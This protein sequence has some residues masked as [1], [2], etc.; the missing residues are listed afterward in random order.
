MPHSL[1]DF[2]D[3]HGGPRTR[4]AFDAPRA[5]RVAHRADE[6]GPVLAEVDRHAAA[7]GWAVGYLRYEAA[8][9]FDAAFVT[10]PPDGPLAWFGLH[11]A[12]RAW[13]DES[14]PGEATAV[15]GAGP[16]R[17]DFDHWVARSHAAIARGD[18]Y[19][20]NLT[21]PWSG[22][23]AGAPEALFHAMRRAQPGGYAAWIAHAHEAV[24]SVSPELFF[25]WDGERLLTRPMKGTAPR[26][27]DAE[28]DR[29]LAEGLRSAPKERA[30]NVMIV[31][32]LRND[33]SR[34]A[35]PGGVRVP[36]LFDL[37][38]L[39]T[40]WQM[41]SDVVARTRP[42]TRLLDVFQAL[43]PCGSI[44][45]APKVQAMR[46]LRELEAGPRGVYCGAVGLV[47]PGGHAT[48]NVAIR[49]VT[50]RGEQLRCGIGSGITADAQADAEWREWRHK[51]AFL[52]R[53]SAPFS[54]L[55]TLAMDHGR[56]RHQAAHLARMAQAARHFGHPW[57]PEQAD[58][59]LQALAA[60]HPS[61]TWRVRLLLDAHGQLQAQAFAL[62]ATE[63]PVGLRLADQAF[64]MTDSEFTRFKTTQRAHYD[65]VASP[66]PAVFDTVLWNERGELTECTRGN[67]ALQLDGRWV[68]PPLH[69]GLLPGVGRAQALADGRLEER[70]VTVDDVPRATGLAFVNSL[71]GWLPA[72]WV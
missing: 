51:R 41:T 21:A 7:G 35:V 9:A 28:H 45:G 31:D 55:E 19:Q 47:R 72:V 34:V 26:G 69:C 70:V 66:D 46:L 44:T 63:V 61:G 40:V 68:T 3:P 25:D 1:I 60:S 56:V 30:E 22:R 54:V 4:V 23:L 12:P 50:A 49:T 53:A 11:D 29:R 27:H 36:S 2:A 65:A 37:N 39:P 59:T 48:F 17:A 62:A 24:L 58:Q 20:V 52:T 16:A 18:V 38:P 14:V 64:E 5:V 57:R 15:W 33:V 43:F 13:P 6:V 10:H 71:R 67:I 32:L 42:G 8:T